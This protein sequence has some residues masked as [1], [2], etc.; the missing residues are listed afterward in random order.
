MKIFKD[1]EGREWIIKVT[2]N[3]ID[4]VQELAGV[5]LLGSD[6]LGKIMTDPLTLCRILVALCRPEME[7][8]GIT[9]EQFAEG[10]CGDV[11]EEAAT[12]LIEDISSFFPKGRRELMLKAAEKVKAAQEKM[13]LAIDQQLDG[14]ISKSTSDAVAAFSAST[15]AS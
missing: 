14:M 7:T 8:R 4:R 6:M 13:L 12:A 2:P 1:S 5:D 15:Q 9:E 3:S 10:F 11:I